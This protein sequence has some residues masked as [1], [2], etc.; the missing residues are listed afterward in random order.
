MREKRITL[1]N[2]VHLPFVR[3][4]T[5]YILI[6]KEDV[7][8]VGLQKARNDPERGRFA[9]PGGPQERDEFAVF[10]GKI[11]IFEDLYAVEGYRDVSK[12]DQTRFVFQLCS[13]SPFRNE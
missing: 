3:R 4:N 2:G 6:F 5:I 10:D 13:P 8:A 7:A 11:Q 1:K 12:I 9:A